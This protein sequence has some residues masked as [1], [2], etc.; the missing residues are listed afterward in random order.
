M[1]EME[2]ET[3]VRLDVDQ[4]GALADGGGDVGVQQ[5]IDAAVDV[6]VPGGMDENQLAGKAYSYL[7]G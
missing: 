5:L 2:G 7:L 1:A 3:G 6:P 4:V